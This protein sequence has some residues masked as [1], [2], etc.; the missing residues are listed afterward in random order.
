MDRIVQIHEEDWGNDLDDW[1]GTDWAN[2]MSGP[3]DWEMQYEHEDRQRKY[4]LEDSIKQVTKITDSPKEEISS[5]LRSHPGSF[6]KGGFIFQSFKKAS[7]F[8]KIYAKRL[9]KTLYLKR[10]DIY[11][12]SPMKFDSY[13]LVTSKT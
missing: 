7:S 1:D 11:R 5:F 3:E 4:Y 6:D 13:W 9:N 2:L 10:E 12:K 8:S